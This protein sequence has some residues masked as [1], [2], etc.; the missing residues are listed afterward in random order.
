MCYASASLKSR[1]TRLVPFRGVELW[2]FCIV[3]ERRVFLLEHFYL[4]ACSLDFVEASSKV[5]K[6]S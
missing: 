3:T 5:V 2:V 1:L 6:N 4:P